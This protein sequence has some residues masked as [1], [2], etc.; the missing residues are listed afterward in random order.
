MQ[1]M[2]TKVDEK[3]GGMYECDGPERQLSSAMVQEVSRMKAGFKKDVVYRRFYMGLSVP[4]IA[5]VMECGKERVKKCLIRWRAEMK[6]KYG[7]T[8]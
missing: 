4:Q 8:V 5:G 2:T 3:N 1:G 7:V 6:G